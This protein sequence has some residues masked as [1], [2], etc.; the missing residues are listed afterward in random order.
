MSI[1]NFGNDHQDVNI[2][3]LWRGAGASYL[4]V[5][6]RERALHAA[7]ESDEPVRRAIDTK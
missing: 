1:A 5:V 3:Y 4:V 6:D 7:T 2:Q